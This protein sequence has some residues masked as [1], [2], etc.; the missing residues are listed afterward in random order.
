MHKKRAR[1]GEEERG[2]KYAGVCEG[3]DTAS[4]RFA[5]AFALPTKADA[6]YA[7]KGVRL[8]AA[9]KPI[10]W[11]RPKMRK[12]PGHLRRSFG[13]RCRYPAKRAER[14]AGAGDG[15]REEVVRSC[16]CNKTK[17]GGN[18]SPSHPALFPE[19][20]RPPPAPKDAG[21]MPAPWVKWD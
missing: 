12:I 4:A 15:R 6:H 2:S 3:P 20:G 5:F 1:R 19:R 11:Y 14:P 7:G 18:R 8:G 13:A 21:G 16:S 10:F 9:D 17:R